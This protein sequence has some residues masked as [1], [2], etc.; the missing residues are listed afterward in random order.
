MADPV[1][2][3]PVCR[4][5]NVLGAQRADSLL[6]FCLGRRDDFCAG[7]SVDAA[8]GQLAEDCE[9]QVLPLRSQA[10]SRTVTG[11]LP[12]VRQMVGLETEFSHTRMTLAAYSQ[13]GYLGLYS[14][15]VRVPDPMNSVTAMYYLHC[16]PRGFDGGQLRLYDTVIRGDR[17]RRAATFQSVEPDHDTIVFF[18]STAFHEVKTLAC[19][20]GQ[21]SDGRFGVNICAFD[22]SQDWSGPQRSTSQVL[23]WM[24]QVAEVTCGSSHLEHHTSAAIPLPQPG[25]VPAATG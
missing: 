23:H 12:M 6:S 17:P 2:P 8:T 14:D 1:V 16:R 25:L 22:A 11:L 19:P 4:F 5:E 7:M 9:L 3:V 20:S 18:P 10:L 13:G 15:A 21:F 24:A